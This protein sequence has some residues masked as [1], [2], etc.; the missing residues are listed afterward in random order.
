MTEP[1]EITGFDEEQYL[2]AHP[3]VAAAVRDAMFQSG[4]KNSARPKGAA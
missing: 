3:D 1:V 4:L 2:A